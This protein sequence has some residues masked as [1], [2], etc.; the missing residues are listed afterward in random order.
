MVEQQLGAS[1]GVAAAYLGSYPDRLW[2]QTALNNGVFL[3]LGP[4]TLNTA[5]GPRFFSVCSTNANLSERRKMSLEDPIKS[6]KIG[7]L[8]LNSDVGWQKYRGLKLSARR[9]SAAGVSLN[10]SYTLSRC[11]GT[12]TA[13]TFNQISQGYS[14]PNNPEFDA[15]PCDQDRTH[16]GTLNMGYETPAV[17]SGIVHTLAS[18]WRVSGILQARSG[19]RLNITS[20]RDNAFT[21]SHS[22]IQRPDLLSDDIYGPGKD[23]DDLQPGQQIDNYFNRAAFAQAS[24]GKLGNATR[25]LAVGPA[26]WQID[27]A[28]SRLVPVGMQRLELRFE[29]F[30][31]LNHF[32]WGNPVTNFNSGAFGRITTQA[33]DPRILQ[34]GIKYSF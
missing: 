3:G 9:R 6:A 30:N 5:T 14:D 8:D 4:C 1:W 10:G 28:I 31:V 13:D 2:A 29:S 12:A 7:A 16:L 23:A 32:N 11:E 20:G 25:N 26:F 22:S 33:G 34:F 17:G 18:N 21:G 24:P 19:S 15:G 27:L